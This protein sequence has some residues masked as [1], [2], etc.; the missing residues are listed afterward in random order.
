MNGPLATLPPSSATIVARPAHGLGDVK[1]DWEAA[2]S[3]SVAYRRSA[4]ALLAVS[5][6]P[7][8][9][10]SIIRAAGFNHSA[11][12]KSHLH[13]DPILRELTLIICI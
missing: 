11:G 3:R 12:M 9:A 1:D 5:T 8:G 2:E 13:L 6:Q 10:N 7:F 4:P